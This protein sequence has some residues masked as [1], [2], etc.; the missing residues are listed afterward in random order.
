[1]TF[2]DALKAA[3]QRESYTQAQAAEK[4]ARLSVRTLQEWESGR[5][6]PPLWTQLLILEALGGPPFG[7]R[8]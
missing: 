1:M 7:F 5:Q 2:K 6:T 3:R 8:R 4:I